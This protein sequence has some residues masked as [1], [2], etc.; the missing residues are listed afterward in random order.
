M[1][2]RV[3]HGHWRCIS[4]CALCGHDFCNMCSRYTRCVCLAY[5]TRAAP[6]P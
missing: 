2:Q 1:V 4:Q 5:R 3:G 6:C